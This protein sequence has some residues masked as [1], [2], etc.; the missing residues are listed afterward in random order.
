MDLILGALFYFVSYNPKLVWIRLWA[1]Q[2]R[3]FRSVLSGPH[4]SPHKRSIRVNFQELFK[5]M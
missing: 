5:L 3:V 1:F 2:F 4:I